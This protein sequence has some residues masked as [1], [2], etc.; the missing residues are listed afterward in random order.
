MRQPCHVLSLHRCHCHSLSGTW[1]ELP[2]VWL[3]ALHI[4]KSTEAG[5]SG[6][7]LPTSIVKGVSL[8]D[9]DTWILRKTHFMC[10]TA[11]HLSWSSG[12]MVS[13][14]P[15]GQM[16]CSPPGGLHVVEGAVLHG[17]FVWHNGKM[18]VLGSIPSQA[19]CRLLL[20]AHLPLPPHSLA[21]RASLLPHSRR[22]RQQRSPAHSGCWR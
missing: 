7:G 6:I 9:G 2:A 3:G 4:P 22:R 20:P 21:R 11:P 14:Q 18:C 12:L 15:Q 13:S 8:I 1:Y 10:Y 5:P 17:H 19:P 16:P